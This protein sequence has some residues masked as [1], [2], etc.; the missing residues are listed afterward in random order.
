[1]IQI[2][3]KK[4]CNGCCA[5]VDVCPT[6]AISLITDEEG[7][8]YPEVDRE[9]CIDCSLCDQV[10]PELNAKDQRLAVG[11]DPVCY[12]AQHKVL[13]SR[14]DSTSGGVF[15][16]FAEAVFAEGGSVAGA[17][18]NEDFSVRHIV[19]E[20]SGDLER[21]R[22]SKYLQSNCEGLYKEIQTRLDSGGQVLACGCPCQMAGLRLFLKKEYDNLILVDFICRGIN[23]PKVFRKHLDALEEKYGSKV[24]YAK[25]KNKEHGWRSL[26]FKAMFENGSVYYGNGREDD[27][28]RGYLQTGYYC[29][30]S[31]FDCKFKEI[32]R[33]ADLT[34]GDFWGV[35]KVA[36]SLDD[37]RG[38]S[39]I[40]CNTPKGGAFIESIKERMDMRTIQ[41][42]DIQPGNRS[43]Y[44]SINVPQDCRADFFADLEKLPFP[45]VAAKYFPKPAEGLARIKSKMKVIYRRLRILFQMMG[46]SPKA[47]VQF[48]WLNLFRQ[49]TNA[50]LLKLHVIV[51]SKHCVFDLH[52]SAKLVVKGLVQFGFSK[53]RGSKMESRLR[54]DENAEL[55]FNDNFILFADADIQIFPGGVLLLEGGP[56]A[57]ANIHCQIVCADRIHV[58]RSVLIGRS[59][60]IRDY[61]AHWIETDG[62]RI[63]AP[64]RI[65]AGCWIGEGAYI[66]KG[67]TVED[68][69]VVAA[70]SMVISN[71]KPRSLVGGSPAVRLKR[72]ITWRR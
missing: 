16:A 27:F 12:A 37:D 19:S 58:G 54:M 72:D 51:P 13:E 48:F 68:G 31:C 69:S 18:Y 2:A 56:G 24:V 28:T 14:M 57:G 25:A 29:R 53:V 67:V 49:N 46:L 45:R 22:S 10:C 66:A 7:F 62:Y 3:D 41:L 55:H 71:V 70:R 44:S 65:G 39:L 43:L 47:W 20:D 34:V 60:V 38:T 5:C 40:M 17:V 4:E 11:G 63:K 9:K 59:V 52:P 30:P 21:I 8:W 64:I 61:D 35:E 1:M 23:S 36:P 42:A 32:P 50:N 26:T 15:S 6:G 33:I